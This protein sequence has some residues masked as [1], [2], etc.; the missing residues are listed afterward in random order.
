MLAFQI[1]SWDLAGH[2]EDHNVWQIPSGLTGKRRACFAP[3]WKDPVSYTHLDVYKRQVLHLLNLMEF[4]F[5]QG[6]DY[7]VFKRLAYSQ[8]STQNNSL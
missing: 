8:E 1:R 7:N 6:G 5:V 4:D 2:A 3:H